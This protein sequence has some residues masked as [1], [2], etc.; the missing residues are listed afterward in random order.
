MGEKIADQGVVTPEIVASILRNRIDMNKFGQDIFTWTLYNFTTAEGLV[1]AS[2][3]QG[4]IPNPKKVTPA[5]RKWMVLNP[6]EPWVLHHSK[7]DIGIISG[8]HIIPVAIGVETTEGKFLGSVAMGFSV[9]KL[10]RKIESST[11]FKALSFVLLDQDMDVVSASTNQPSMLSKDFFHQKIDNVSQNGKSFTELKKSISVDGVTYRFIRKINRYPYVL[12]IGEN[13]ELVA[14]TFKSELIPQILNTIVMVSFFSVLLY[15]FHR[16]VIKPSHELA[17][18]AEKISQGNLD[19][20][21]SE[22]SSRK[23]HILS[24]QLEK[25]KKAI[26]QEQCVNTE[27]VNTKTK[28]EEALKIIRKADEEKDVFVK[29]MYQ[30][31]KIPLKA[32][33]NGMH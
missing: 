12:L 19:V 22:S 21:I 32:I 6:K 33:I 13:D 15:L 4:V 9:P 1:I 17:L 25:M 3:T 8:E 31:L 10:I 2:S 11:S 27:L 16:L 26:L 30:V 18:A 28:L 20:E 7:P 29:N 24:L 23:M 5:K 14:N